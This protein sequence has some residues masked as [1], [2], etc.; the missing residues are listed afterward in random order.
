MLKGHAFALKGQLSHTS[1]IGLYK[2]TGIHRV[3]TATNS[4][5]IDPFSLLIADSE[6]K[7]GLANAPA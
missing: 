6:A 2:H 5:K 1:Y 3:L 4:S 7:R